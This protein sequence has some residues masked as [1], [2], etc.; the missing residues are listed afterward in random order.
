[1]SID[2]G[3]MADAPNE[4][5]VLVIGGGPGGSSAAITLAQLGHRVTVL[6][7][8]RHPRFHI[9]ESLLPANLPLMAQL[10]VL[11]QVRAIGM[12]KW[13]AEFYSQWHGRGETFEFA[14][15]WN[16]S[17][18]FAYQVRRSE[19]DEILIRRAAQVGAQVVEGCRARDVQVQPDGSTLVHAQHEDGRNATWRARFVVDASGRDTFFG[20]RLQSKRRNPKHNSACMFAHFKGAHRYPEAKRAGLITVYWFEHGW[21]WFIPLADGVTSIGAVVWPYY[22]KARDCDLRDYFMRTIGMSAEL[23]ARLKDAELVSEV[24]ATGNYSYECER[25]HG[26][27]FLMVGDAFA[28]VDPVFSTGVM[29][30]MN[31]GIEGAKTVDV[32][33][34][35]PARAA[36]ALERHQY[37]MHHGPKEYS[38]FIHH[39][40][41][42]T[43][44]N[45]FMSPRNLLRM[46]EAIL[47]LLAGDIFGRAPIGLSLRAFKVLYYINSLLTPR[48]SL[49]AW[50][51]RAINIRPV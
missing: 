9:G 7:K 41:G 12:Q 13:G 45:L 22:M 21:L 50:R 14:D 11:E 33:L 1:M 5:D 23:S 46:K 27:G 31:S 44:R 30:A 49:A 19:F 38:W 40:T 28:F 10:G 20:N 15:S 24:E 29:L 26:E 34:R 25:A 36:H 51:Q 17:L 18:Q 16:K 35:E 43:M 2:T 48:R 8:A 4:T 39:L 37:L 32:C 47:S 42:P 3:A 6:E